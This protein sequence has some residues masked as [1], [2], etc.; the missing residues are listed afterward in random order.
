MAQ[1]LPDAAV[2]SPALQQDGV[3]TAEN[4]GRVAKYVPCSKQSVLEIVDETHLFFQIRH[5]S[6]I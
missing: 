5:I 1:S 3:F 2:H 6:R 4:T